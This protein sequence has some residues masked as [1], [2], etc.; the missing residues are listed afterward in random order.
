M[1]AG[2]L[3]AAEL[4]ELTTANPNSITNSVTELD[5]AK[6]AYDALESYKTSV[7]NFSRLG[8]T[9]DIT[10]DKWLQLTSVG[11]FASEAEVTRIQGL[12]PAAQTNLATVMQ[13]I[14]D[15][16]IAIT[17]E[18]LG[19]PLVPESDITTKSLSDLQNTL[20]GLSTQVG[21]ARAAKAAGGGG[22]TTQ[23]VAQHTVDRIR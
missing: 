12:V 19:I 11:S 22:T 5:Q 18:A 2:G 17:T 9:P 1:I 15:L 21:R 8:I 14:R 13:N 6:Q 20:A 16:N 4:A 10:S 23:T 3:T 7:P